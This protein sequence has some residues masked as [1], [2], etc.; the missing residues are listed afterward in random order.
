MHVSKEYFNY[1]ITIY[2]ANWKALV[3]G[4]EDRNG[5][6]V[7]DLDDM[8]NG[9]SQAEC[10]KEKSSSPCSSTTPDA[11]TI[12][13]AIIG[14]VDTRRSATFIGFISEVRFETI[15]ATEVESF[16][17]IPVDVLCNMMRVAAKYADLIQFWDLNMQAQWSEGGI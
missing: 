16:R 8:A 13:N 11:A 12:K 15:G 3:T 7:S 14:S 2:T 5:N 17:N 1:L 6:G 9:L 10:Y 4:N